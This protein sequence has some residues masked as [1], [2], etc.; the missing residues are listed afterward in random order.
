MPIGQGYVSDRQRRFFHTDTAKAAGIT[1]GSIDRRDQESKGKKLPEIAPK[2]KKTTR[3]HNAE[4][5]SY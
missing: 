3:R 1:Q 4:N 2:K 5:Y